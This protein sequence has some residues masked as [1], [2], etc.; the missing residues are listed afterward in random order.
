MKSWLIVGADRSRKGANVQTSA[1]QRKRSATPENRPDKER[2][3]ARRRSGAR[4][5]V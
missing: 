2:S 5:V 3:S 4:E 1:S